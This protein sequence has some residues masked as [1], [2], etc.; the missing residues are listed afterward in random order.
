MQ[1]D[2]L[3]EW[4]RLTEL[5]SRMYDDELL[6]LAADSVDLT[7]TAQQALRQEMRRRGL[8]EPQDASTARKIPEPMR[9]RRAARLGSLGEAPK[10]VPDTPDTEG[11][12]D[13]PHEYTWKTL[14]CECDDR[15]E[16]LQICE[17]L[18]RAGIE[19]WIEGPGGSYSPYSQLDQRTPRIL[20]AADRFG[21][22]REVAARPIPQEIVKQS[23]MQ[24]PEF[25]TPVCPKC[26]AG[27]PVL[28]GVDP[29]NTWRCE[30]CGN[31][32]TES[33]GDLAENP[34]EFEQ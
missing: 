31:E 2:P 32:W 25:E 30:A 26:G 1:N 24:A 28:E 29:F 8:G 23:Q 7:E 13:E 21:E 17:V 9:E 10:L 6:N 34:E 22:A 12:N 15:E 33:A 5:Y 4:Q 3:V 18:R 19:S 20:V 27:D 16:A 11:E 14:L